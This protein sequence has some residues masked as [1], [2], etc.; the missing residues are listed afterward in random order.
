MFSFP[1][2]LWQGGDVPP[3]LPKSS[4]HI[5]LILLR[6]FWDSLSAEE[7]RNPERPT[8]EPQQLAS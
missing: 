6:I 1:F 3:V 5:V 4:L 7:K 2:G 8:T